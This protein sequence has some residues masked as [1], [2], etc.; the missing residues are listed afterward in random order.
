[1][2]KNFEKIMYYTPNIIGY[3]ETILP[4]SNMVDYMNFITHPIY[5]EFVNDAIKSLKRRKIEK[6]DVKKFLNDVGLVYNDRCDDSFVPTH[7]YIFGSL[8]TSIE[9]IYGNIL[10]SKNPTYLEILEMKKTIRSIKE[11]FDDKGITNF[12]QDQVNYSNHRKEE[13]A[14]ALPCFIKILKEI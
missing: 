1:M 4:L 2:I 5:V 6:L 8:L 3:K 13:F 12:T 7:K 11:Y 9:K 14:N 10:L